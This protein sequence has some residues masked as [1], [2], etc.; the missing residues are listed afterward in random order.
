MN[1]RILAASLWL[2]AGWYVGAAVAMF[3]GLPEGAGL[4]PG[5]VMAA[6]IAADPLQRLWS[7]AGSTTKDLP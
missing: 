3:V 6:F 7:S 5:V 1:K 2:F 4:L